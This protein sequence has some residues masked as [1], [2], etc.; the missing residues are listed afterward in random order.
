MEM[1]RSSLSQDGHVA[2]D[3][4]KKNK[5]ISYL[6]GFP[7]SMQYE[8]RMHSLLATSYGMGVGSDF[9]GAVP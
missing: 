5:C 1:H 2:S 3:G 8:V 6:E 7:S 9:E 4:S